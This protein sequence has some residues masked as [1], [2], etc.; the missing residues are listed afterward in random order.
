MVVDITL[1]HTDVNGGNDV[2][3]NGVK[4]TYAWKNFVQGKAVIG[5]TD[6]PTKAQN[7]FES[8]IITIQGMW[9]IDDQTDLNTPKTNAETTNEVIC[10]KLLVDFAT[11]QTT[12]EIVLTI[13]AGQ[14]QTELGGRPTTGYSP[15]ANT[16][17][18]SFAVV[19]DSF[20][21][22]FDSSIREGQKWDYNITFVETG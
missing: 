16:L 15:G 4:V 3:L 12:D 2:E 9:D 7:G 21:I 18:S 22:T 17:L 6:I 8:P 11:L 14:N 10:Q 13:K 20:K 1:N 5:V 19:L